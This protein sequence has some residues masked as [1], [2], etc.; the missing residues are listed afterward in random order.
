[1]PVELPEEATD[2]ER[3][4]SSKEREHDILCKNYILNGLEDDFYDCYADNKNTAMMIWDALQMKY[5]TDKVIA[6]KYIYC[7]PLPMLLDGG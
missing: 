1:M 4:A 3:A 2:E 6:K 5:D 7:Q